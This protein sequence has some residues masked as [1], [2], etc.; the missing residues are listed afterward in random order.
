[1]KNEFAK[2]KYKSQ[3][4]NRRL[5]LGVT[6]TLLVILGIIWLIPLAWIFLSAFRCEY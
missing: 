3:S 1:M 4:A 5:S 6:Y 2:K